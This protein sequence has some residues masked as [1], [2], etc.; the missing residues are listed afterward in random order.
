MS[1]TAGRV[2][3]AITLA[4]S[5]ACLGWFGLVRFSFGT[6]SS[7]AVLPGVIGLIAALATVVGALMFARFVEASVHGQT[8]RLRRVL[9]RDR[10][11]AVSEVDE[12]VLL[13]DLRLPSRT[14]PSSVTRV[15]L[16]R[17][18]GTVAAFTPR[19][20]ELVD[21]L[22]SLGFRPLVIDEPT[23]PLRAS[24]SYPGSVGFAELVVEP[25]LWACV[26]IPVVVVAWLVWDAAGG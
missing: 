8:I 6:W 2:F 1:I 18:G 22:R 16:R 24:R 14:A 4:M 5:V 11:I 9:G 25:V 21:G 7:A 20:S 3:L 26:V 13:L 19:G 23:T 17:A 10:T 15:V 12:V